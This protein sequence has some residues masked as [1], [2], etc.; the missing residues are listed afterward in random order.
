MMV[1]ASGDRAIGRS[2]VQS[3]G[4]SALGFAAAAGAL[5]AAGAFGMTFIFRGAD[6]VRTIWITAL[7]AFGTQMAA[8][9]LIKTL[10]RQNLMMGWGAGTLIRF[11]TLGV[12]AL[13]V[14]L[15][16]LPVAP[17]LLSLALFYFISSVIEPLFLRS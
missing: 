14:V 6:D 2:G 9:P 5:I 16:H 3:L 13:I 8:F 12:Y 11:L 1:A 7:V 4:R 17:A 15:A 10:I